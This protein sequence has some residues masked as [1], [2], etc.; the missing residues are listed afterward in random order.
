H[1]LNESLEDRV[2][3]RTAELERAHALALEENAQRQYAEALLRQSQKME[4]I[5]QLTGGVAHD[6]NNLLMAIMGNLDLLR[7]RFGQDEKAARLIEDA[8]I[9]AKRGAALTQR[10]LA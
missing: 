6:F 1:H 5:G 4:I 9:G 8:L 3:A 7:R 2:A 10:L